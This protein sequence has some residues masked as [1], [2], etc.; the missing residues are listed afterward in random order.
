MFSYI[1]N[2][3]HI[4]HTYVHIKQRDLRKKKKAST[5]LETKKRRSRKCLNR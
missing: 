4:K 2:N 1:D 5:R 3:A